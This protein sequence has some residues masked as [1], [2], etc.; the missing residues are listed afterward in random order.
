M[1]TLNFPARGAWGNTSSGNFRNITITRLNLEAILSKY[2]IVLKDCVGTRWMSSVVSKNRTTYTFKI[3]AIGLCKAIHN[4]GLSDIYT[5]DWILRYHC[6]DLKY[7][8][9]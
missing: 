3:N 7:T 8:Q 1:D 6:R 2:S 9:Q 5:Q 4:S